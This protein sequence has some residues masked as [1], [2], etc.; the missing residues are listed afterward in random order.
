MKQPTPACAISMAATERG[1]WRQRGRRAARSLSV[2]AS[3]QTPSSRP[4]SASGL[5]TL[6]TPLA[7]AIAATPS[8]VSS[9]GARRLRRMSRPSARCQRTKGPTPSSSATGAIRG[10]NTASK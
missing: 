6:L 2:L 8:S 5:L 7:Q 9:S 1:S 10:T 4:V 3:T